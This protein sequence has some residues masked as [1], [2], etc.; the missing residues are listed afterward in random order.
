MS[1]L[2]LCY[3][4]LP[5]SLT[6]FM[7]LSTMAEKEIPK[8]GTQEHL[9]DVLDRYLNIWHGDLSLIDSKLAPT[10]SLY[11]DRFPVANGGSR[12][13]EIRTAKG[14]RAFVVRYKIGWEKY[15]FKSRLLV[16]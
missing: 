9:R 16:T 11:A 5:G 7:I 1:S 12:P 6:T 10:L 3:S 8:I 13:M 2:T 4:K 14:F 15:E